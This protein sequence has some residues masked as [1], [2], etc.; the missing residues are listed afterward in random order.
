MPQVDAIS[1]ITSS[2]AR[3]TIAE[4]EDQM[5]R[6]TQAAQDLSSQANASYKILRAAIQSGDVLAAQVALDDLERECNPASSTDAQPAPQS[7]PATV[8]VPG[9]DGNSGG[10]GNPGVNSAQSA[11]IDTLA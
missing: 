10:T 5:A 11:S 1:G 3:Q 6:Y 9:P 4:L 2:A 8:G 7:N